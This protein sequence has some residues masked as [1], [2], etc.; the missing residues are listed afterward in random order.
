MQVNRSM[1]PTPK[2]E[3]SGPDYARTNRPESDGDDLATAVARLYAS[4][5][6]GDH[7]LRGA[8]SA[9]ATNRL[10]GSLNPT[11]VEWLM[12]YPLAWTALKDSAMRSFRKLRLKS[13]QPLPQSNEE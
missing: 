4:P 10:G 8:K 1:W 12:G 5:S 6:Y 13:S 2:G 7:K 9:E 3:P 11:W